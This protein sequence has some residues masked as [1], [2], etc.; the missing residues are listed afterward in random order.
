MWRINLHYRRLHEHVCTLLTS[1]RVSRT[2]KG[3]R[4]S[5]HCLSVL[6]NVHSATTYALGIVPCTR[7]LPITN[8]RFNVNY[9]IADHV[10]IFQS[11][12]V[13][14]RTFQTE[15][16]PLYALTTHQTRRFRWKDV[17]IYL[18]SLWQSFISTTMTMDERFSLLQKHNDRS[19]TIR[20]P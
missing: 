4:I 10:T 3:A 1:D 19:Q 8:R 14:R 9:S 18:Q 20:F 13:Q 11:G 2:L 12:L 6:I 5:L 16:W 7:L 17:Q 15:L